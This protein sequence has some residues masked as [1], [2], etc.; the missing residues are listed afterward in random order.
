VPF[1]CAHLSDRYCRRRRND[2]NRS[3][4]G[5]GRPRRSP[6]VVKSD[7]D[8]GRRSSRHSTPYSR[9]PIR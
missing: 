9:H 7:A 6:H 3:A 4:V 2:L 5:Q 8:R 1:G